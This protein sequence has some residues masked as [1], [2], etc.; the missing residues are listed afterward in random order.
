M[1]AEDGWVVGL[2]ELH[3]MAELGAIIEMSIVLRK[4]DS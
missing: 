1:H 3:R 4:K 2:S